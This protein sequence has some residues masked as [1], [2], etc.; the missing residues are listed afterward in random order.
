[1]IRI[2]SG[3]TGT[4]LARIESLPAGLVQLPATLYKTSVASGNK[5][6]AFSGNSKWRNFT[7]P[8]STFDIERSLSYVSQYFLVSLQVGS[9]TIKLKRAKIILSAFLS[10]Q[11]THLFIQ[12]VK[13]KFSVC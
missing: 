3:K 5:K 13:A 8:L 4:V 12:N 7:V 11:C 9:G 2:A 10:I 6:M 1:M